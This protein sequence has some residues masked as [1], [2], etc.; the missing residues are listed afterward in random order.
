M[1]FWERL[2]IEIK[3]QN[4]TQEWLANHCGFSYG[5]LRKW[6]TNK[7]MPNADQACSIAKALGVTVEYLVTGE[8]SE[9]LSPE[10]SHAIRY[11]RNLP[12]DV[13]PRVITLLETAF[14]VYEPSPL[15]K[16]KLG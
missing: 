13:M 16:E 5:T 10:K 6:F 4:T 9:A 7:T 11:V 1:D 14:P 15:T 12:D 2:K 3:S 8:T